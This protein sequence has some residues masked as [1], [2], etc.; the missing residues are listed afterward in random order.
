MR[1]LKASL[2]AAAVLTGMTMWAN[3]SFW[4]DAYSGEREPTDLTIGALDLS[5]RADSS[6]PS[7]FR[8]EEVPNTRHVFL[9]AVGLESAPSSQVTVQGGGA[10]LK[11]LITGPEGPLQGAEVVIQ[12]F[13]NDGAAV[14]RTQTNAEGRWRVRNVHGGRFRVR[15]FVP[16]QFGSSGSEVFFL[17]D[18]ETRT[19]NVNLA[20]P[21]EVPIV[22]GIPFGDAFVGGQGTAIVFVANRIVDELG[23]TH[24]VAGAGVNVTLLVDGVAVVLTSS[25]T[26]VTDGEG[27]AT[28]SFS[29]AAGSTGQAIAQ[30]NDISH[31]VSV[32]PCQIPPEPVAPPAPEQ[33]DQE[34]PAE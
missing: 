14:V 15:A 9:P 8:L 33:P 25:P 16:G 2:V 17:A 4:V 29:C 27:Y 7:P 31:A 34:E 18:G 10:Q 32:T 6:G 12:R 24:Q 28:F 26:A 11:G 21:S 13:T 5:F 20:R 1:V 3:R 23:K 22:R 19:H 30:I